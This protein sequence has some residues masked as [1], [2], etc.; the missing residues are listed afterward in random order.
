MQTHLA[1]TIVDHS[2]VNATLAMPETA[3]LVAMSTSVSLAITTAI[4]MLRVLIMTEAST[5]LAM[6]ATPGTA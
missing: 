3:F 1:R 6:P 5:V 2:A 4:S